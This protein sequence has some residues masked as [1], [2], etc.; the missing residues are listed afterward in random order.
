MLCD[1]ASFDFSSVYGSVVGEIRRPTTDA[2]ADYMVLPASVQYP[3]V[4]GGTMIVSTVI[5]FLLGQKPSKREIFAIALSFL[6]IL[7]LVFIT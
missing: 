6:G 2:I 3:F 4:T 5:S 1:S 7:A